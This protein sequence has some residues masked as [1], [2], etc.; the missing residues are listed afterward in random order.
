M[1]ANKITYLLEDPYARVDDDG[2]FRI[3]NSTSHN[4]LIIQSGGFRQ[5]IHATDRYWSYIKSSKFEIISPT[6]KN[7]PDIYLFTDKS[8]KL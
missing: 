1:N 3:T 6:K 2:T 8:F 4:L 5:A 7:D